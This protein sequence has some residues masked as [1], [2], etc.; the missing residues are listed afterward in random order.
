ML[1]YN[2][3]SK[4]N[5]NKRVRTWYIYNS[6]EPIQKVFVIKSLTT[7]CNLLGRYMSCPET[8]DWY[9]YNC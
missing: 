2:C 7:N 8:C 4:A 6:Q 1:K 5:P 3:Y 9:M